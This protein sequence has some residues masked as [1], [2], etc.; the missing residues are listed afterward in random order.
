MA[1][2]RWLGPRTPARAPTARRRHLDHQQRGLL[3]PLALR[4]ISHLLTSSET[5]RS[6][7]TKWEASLPRAPMDRYLSPMSEG[8]RDL[9]PKDICLRP[10][11][12][13]LPSYSRLTL[14]LRCRRPSALSWRVELFGVASLPRWASVDVELVTPGVSDRRHSLRSNGRDVE[15]ELHR[16]MALGDDGGGSPAQGRSSRWRGSGRSGTAMGR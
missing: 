9:H 10:L 16:S 3:R 11:R 7:D 5:R 15:P 4:D 8:H 1:A 12:L 2:A 6:I 14:R 13:N